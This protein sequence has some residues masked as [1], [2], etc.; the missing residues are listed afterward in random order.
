M[1]TVL[2][3]LNMKATD[4]NHFSPWLQLLKISSNFW[5]TMDDGQ[6]SSGCSIEASACNIEQNEKVWKISSR[7][8]WECF[9]LYF[10]CWPPNAWYYN[11]RV[12]LKWASCYNS[13][14][15]EELFK[16]IL[17][18]KYMS[19]RWIQL[20]SNLNFCF[21]VMDSEWS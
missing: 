5:P 19:R 21:V 14:V 3:S 17:T 9:R 1:P 8:N 4:V 18:A 2:V 10:Y 7:N 16:N 6:V 12:C 11:W 13:D 15:G 20:I